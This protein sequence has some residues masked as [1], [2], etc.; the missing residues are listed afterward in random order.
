VTAVATKRRPRHERDATPQA[1]RARGL[2]P[3]CGALLH[4]SIDMEGVWFE[5]RCVG[6]AHGHGERH[7]PGPWLEVTA[8][9]KEIF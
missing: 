4:R 5:Q 3:V 1:P 2:Q 9:V 6:Q 8:D 7:L